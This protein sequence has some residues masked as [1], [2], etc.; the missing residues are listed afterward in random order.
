MG[1]SE[2]LLARADLAPCPRDHRVTAELQL[3]VPREPH[4]DRDAS[5]EILAARPGRAALF[6]ADLTEV[7]AF[8][9]RHGSSGTDS[10]AT[11]PWADSRTIGRFVAP[12]L[13]VCSALMVYTWVQRVPATE[14]RDASH[15]RATCVLRGREVDVISRLISQ[16]D[17][18]RCQVRSQA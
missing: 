3:L 5:M 1:G 6:A 14:R 2:L 17:V 12:R 10:R 15:L 13:S 16:I 9:E 4:D 11:E 8:S 18:F 7:P